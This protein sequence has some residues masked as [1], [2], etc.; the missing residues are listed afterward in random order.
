MSYL[1][2]ASFSGKGRPFNPNPW[3]GWWG[4][5]G[6]GVGLFVYPPQPL[7]GRVRVD[8]GGGEGD[9]P[10][11]LLHGHEV[12]PGIQEVGRK[13][14]AQG[15]NAETLISSG[16]LEVLPDGPLDGAPGEPT[17]S[18]IQEEGVGI[19]RPGRGSQSL[20]PPGLITPNG[21]NGPPGD[22]DDPLLPALSGQA[23]LIYQTPTC[24]RPP[25]SPMLGQLQ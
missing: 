3:A 24:F 2:K 8:L 12:R 13:G 9:M 7:L 4:S 15:M 11:E 5:S 18:G 21:P 25:L 19:L 16:L 6:P 23:R 10:Q 22:R 20:L 17:S 14:V 1:G